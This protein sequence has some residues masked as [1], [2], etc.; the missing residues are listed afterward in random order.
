M[1]LGRK[2]G[3]K[4]ASKTQKMFLKNFKSILLLSRRRFCVFNICCVGAQTRNH[5]RDTEETLTLDVSRM[6]P[7][8]HTQATYH[9][10]TEFGSHKQWGFIILG[11]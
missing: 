8:L 2:H 3:S 7:R 11:F 9:E 4:N 10:D 6:F 5:L 1:H